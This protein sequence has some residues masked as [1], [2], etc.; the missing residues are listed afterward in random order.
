V[1][2]LF[3]EL[4]GTVCICGRRKRTKETFCGSCYRSLPRPMQLALYR[5]MGSGYEEAY[6][7]AVRT[8]K[9]DDW[10]TEQV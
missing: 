2:D 3:K 1:S 7:A 4:M 8:L 6:A 9:G 10:A 5:R